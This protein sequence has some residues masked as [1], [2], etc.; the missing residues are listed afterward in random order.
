MPKT[1]S[2]QDRDGE[3]MTGRTEVTGLAAGELFGGLDRFGTGP[4]GGRG[5][6]LGDDLYVSVS[7]RTIRGERTPTTGLGSMRLP[8]LGLLPY[9]S[10]L[11]EV[12]R[13]RRSGAQV[14][15]LVGAGAVTAALAVAAV[16]GSTGAGPG[17]PEAATAA[18]AVATSPTVDATPAGPA[19]SPSSQ[20]PDFGPRLQQDRQVRS[21][22]EAD[23]PDAPQALL[24]GG[25]L[26]LVGSVP[27]ARIADALARKAAT[28]LGSDAVVDGMT[29][30]PGASIP[31]DVPVRVAERIRFRS[32]SATVDGE[33]L[34]L[35][36]AWKAVLAAN[37]G[38]RMRITGYADDA[39]PAATNEKLAWDRASALASWMEE[40]GIDPDRIEVT[41]RGSADP[42][43]P[44]TTDAGRAENRRIQ[45]DL[46]ALLMA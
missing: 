21:V 40:S 24:S 42:A 34:G 6:R 41:S 22:A 29:I 32:S 44:N 33:W 25:K 28:I 16:T 18:T 15:M 19:P 45:V 23:S 31:G 2:P 9:A 11:P 13:T 46:F 8:D 12:P 36:E 26:V 3:A 30:D 17:G 35:A 7:Q 5:G 10:D 37:P 4:L 20:R 14:R 43:A 39:G 1:T 38:V 27:D